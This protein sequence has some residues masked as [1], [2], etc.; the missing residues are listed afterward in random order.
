MHITTAYL[1]LCVASLS[2]SLSVLPW[3]Q[4][5]FTQYLSKLSSTVNSLRVSCGLDTRAGGGAS[6]GDDW[7][8]LQ[9]AFTLIQCC[10]ECV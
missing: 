10:G 7:V 9:V 4:A 8:Y 6:R 3:F 1:N 2:L 5:F